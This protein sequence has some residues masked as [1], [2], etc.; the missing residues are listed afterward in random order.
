MAA[1]LVNFQVYHQ[2]KVTNQ[3]FGIHKV[4]L[5]SSADH[6]IVPKLANDS[7]PSSSVGRLDDGNNGS[8]SA[9]YAHN[10]YQVDL[11]G[12]VAGDKLW[13]ATRHV[14]RLNYRPEA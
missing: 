3:T 13:F 5:L 8:L 2:V 11:D 14:G 7:N 6:V 1:A 4:T 9:F 10:A 12:G